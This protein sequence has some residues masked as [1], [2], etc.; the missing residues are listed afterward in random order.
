MH[1]DNTIDQKGATGM[2]ESMA[3]AAGTVNIGD[4]TVNRIGLGTNRVS[5]TEQSY[6]LLKRAVELGV[7]FIDTAW[8]YQNG[9]SETAIGNALSPYE[10]GVV[11]ATKGG[12]EDTKPTELAGYLEDSLRR[13]KLDHVELYQLHRVNPNVPIEESVGELKKLQ[14]Q[15][16]I[17]H[18]GLSEVSV[19]QIE[20]ARKITPIVSVQNQYNVIERKHESVVEYCTDT[21]IV[22]IPW[23]PLG[24]L[25]GG[26]ETVDKLLIDMARQY[27]L[28][29]RQLAL[30]WLLRRSPMMLPIPGTLSVEHLED[31]LRAGQVR[32]SDED[33]ESLLRA[34]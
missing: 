26:A 18:I 24:G 20:R 1:S 7:N 3:S 27:D 10:K 34:V 9:A 6:R 15:G 22:F 4:M 30:A 14:R 5:D 11:I 17:R 13:L 2:D 31:N 8:R 32:L 25:A 23:F 21:S 16:K 33:Y 29:T 19:E 12:W 28:S